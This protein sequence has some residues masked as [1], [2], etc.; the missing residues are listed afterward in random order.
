MSSRGFAQHERTYNLEVDVE[1]FEEYRPGGYH[2]V[3][4]GDTFNNGRYQVVHKLGFGGYSTIWLAR[5]LV[6]H[7]YVS[8][9]ILVAGESRNSNE[10]KILRHLSDGDSGQGKQFIPCLLDE[11]SIEGPNGQHSCLVQEV[12]GCS[13]PD[14]KENSTSLMFPPEAARSIAAQ[15]MIGLAYLHARGVCHADLHLRNL[16]LRGPDL[17]QLK[18]DAL[19]QQYRLDTVPIRR[20]DGAPVRPHAPPQAVYPLNIEMAADE[21]TNPRLQIIDYGT[22]YLWPAG[23]APELH[24]PALYLPPE[25][26]FGEPIT[27]AAD[28]W[29]LGVSLYEVLGERPLFESFAS[30]RDDLL[31]DT[32]NALGQPPKRW[33]DKWAQ[34]QEFFQP[35]GSYIEDIKRIHTP[36]F[37]PLQQRLWQMGRGE[38]RETCEWDVEGGEMRALEELLRSMLKFEP[39]ER[40]TAE[41]LL[42]SEYMVKWAMPAWQRQLQRTG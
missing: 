32:I 11:F 12:A 34:R 17:H 26:F 30:D 38:T 10:G 41:E 37:R 35:D 2:P 33:W 29:T 8:L 14:S 15:I 4:V 27:P 16:L 25:D 9:K 21:L 39:S 28:I 24:S 40:A 22:S 36:K 31:A 13:I 3:I 19:Y 7:R 20:V 1:D 5:D 42:A 23:S 6:H 18:P